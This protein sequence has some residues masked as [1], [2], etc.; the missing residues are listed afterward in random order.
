MDPVA[1]ILLLVLVTAAIILAIVTTRRHTNAH[2]K[3]LLSDAEFDVFK[4]LSEAFQ[5]QYSIYPKIEAS[6]LFS[7]AEQDNKNNADPV[8]MLHGRAVDF[9]IC[10]KGSV[11]P[12]AAVLLCEHADHT[13]DRFYSAV[14]SAFAEVHLPVIEIDLACGFSTAEIANQIVTYQRQPSKQAPIPS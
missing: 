8:H 6:R 7:V 1:P 4:R 12:V 10:Y 3:P 13:G 14:R 2:L 11:E 9:L 5:S